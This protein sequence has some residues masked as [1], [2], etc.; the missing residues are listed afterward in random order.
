MDMYWLVWP[1]LTPTGRVFHWILDITA[2][3][4]VGGMAVAFGL[5]RLRGRYTCR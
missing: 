5:F 2:F 1:A 4:G 3:V